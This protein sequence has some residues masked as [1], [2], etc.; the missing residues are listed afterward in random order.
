VLAQ[1]PLQRGGVY[2]WSGLH[3]SA[4]RAGLVIKS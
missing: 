4:R 3:L 1:P 2:V